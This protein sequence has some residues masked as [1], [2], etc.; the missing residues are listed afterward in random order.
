MSTPKEP[1]FFSTEYDRSIDWYR[2]CF[3][4][5]SKARGEAS[6]NYTKRHV[7]DKVPE[8]MHGLLPDVKLLY[9]IRD[10]IERAISHYTHNCAAAGADHRET[11]PVDEALLPPSESGYVQTSRYY[12]QISRYLKHYSLEDILFIESE[13]LREMRSDVLT[14]IFEFI[15]VDT[16]S[17]KEIPREDHHLSGNKEGWSKTGIFLTQTSVGKTIKDAAKNILPNTLSDR[18]KKMLKYNVNKPSL[19]TEAEEKLYSYLKNDVKK[20]QRITG[21]NF[22]LWSI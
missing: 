21:K 3:S 16:N 17:E 14:E 11:R 22:E 5:A 9:L 12:Y 19:K 2:Q 18:V 6:V 15:N 13:R 4:S 7:F 8:R 20:L 1:N 10:P